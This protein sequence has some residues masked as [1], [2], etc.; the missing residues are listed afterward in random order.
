MTSVDEYV[1]SVCNC[2]F[3][4]YFTSDSLLSQTKTL[5]NLFCSMNINNL[6]LNFSSLQRSVI[7]FYKWHFLLE[8][9]KKIQLRKD[10]WLSYQFISRLCLFCLYV[11]IAM[12]RYFKRIRFLTCQIFTIW[13]LLFLITS[14]LLIHA[15]RWFLRIVRKTT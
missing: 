13:L 7:T 12:S 11:C 9:E 2:V 4:C 6:E 5:P 8:L 1:N 3:W 10:Q 14:T 15:K